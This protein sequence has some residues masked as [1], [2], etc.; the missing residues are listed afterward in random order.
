MTHMV[1]GQRSYRFILIPIAL[2]LLL[3]TLFM[4]WVIIS[5]QGVSALTPIDLMLGSFE[6]TESQ[7]AI[8]DREHPELLFLDLVSSYKVQ[9]AY[10]FWLSAYI[11][12]IISMVLSLLIPRSRTT[13]VLIAGSLALAAAIAWFYSIEGLKTNFVNQAAMTGGLIGE[14]FK[15]NER[16]LIDNIVRMGFGPYVVALAGAVGLFHFGQ[17][18]LKRNYQTDSRTPGNDKPA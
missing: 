12:S 1:L 14:E 18:Y 15:G 9:G 3:P 10:F 16:Y 4:P 5:F 17:Y 8:I 2:G 13:T 6:K 11:I 7:S